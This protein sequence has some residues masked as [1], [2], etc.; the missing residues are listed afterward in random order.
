MHRD[1]IHLHLFLY[2]FGL[3]HSS[4]DSIS[5]A[6]LLLRSL[7]LINFLVRVA[8]LYKIVDISVSLHS[9]ASIGYTGNKDMKH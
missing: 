1:L 4:F 6:P 5:I 9:K 8:S 7:S 3:R 2:I